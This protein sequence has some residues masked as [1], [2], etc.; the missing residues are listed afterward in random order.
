MRTLPAEHQTHRR[1]LDMSA[2]D[3]GT[4]NPPSPARSGPPNKRPRVNAVPS[5]T[6]APGDA[7]LRTVTASGGVGRG[8][9]GFI[10]PF[11]PP[12]AG[13]AGGPVVGGTRNDGTAGAQAGA[14]ASAASAAQGG[15]GSR[16]SLG[17][18]GPRS[19]GGEYE[20]SLTVVS[21][22]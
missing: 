16:V 5:N 1:S 7:R 21:R 9:G 11:A 15:Q 14:E 17:A 22:F 20:D 4:H 18:G 19:Q 13:R 10:N 3:R 6:P 2:Q 12:N 8:R